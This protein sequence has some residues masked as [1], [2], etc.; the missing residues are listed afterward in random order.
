[1]DG[2]SLCP[3]SLWSGSGLAVG[4]VLPPSLC[5]HHHCCLTALDRVGLCPPLLATLLTAIPKDFPA[6]AAS[7]W[8]IPISVTWVWYHLIMHVFV[9]HMSPIVLL[10]IS[11]WQHGFCLGRSTMTAF[12]GALPVLELGSRG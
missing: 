11:D 7:D 10:C 5:A 6:A 9:Y 2:L 3:R 4:D 12:L 1:M 8:Y